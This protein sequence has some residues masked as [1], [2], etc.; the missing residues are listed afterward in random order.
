MRWISAHLILEQLF[1]FPSTVEK[2]KNKLLDDEL[3]RSG[4]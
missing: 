2:N 1:S 4:Y 3:A